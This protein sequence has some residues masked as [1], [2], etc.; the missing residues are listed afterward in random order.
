M[1]AK[2]VIPLVVALGLGV[3]A[4]KLGKDMMMKGRQGGDHTKVIKL[5]VAKEDLA[6]G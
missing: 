3:V 6:P 4:A 5:V 2:T 1:N